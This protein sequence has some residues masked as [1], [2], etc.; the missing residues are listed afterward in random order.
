[1]ILELNIHQYL[2][3]WLDISGTPIQNLFNI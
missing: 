2:K 3:I 1:M